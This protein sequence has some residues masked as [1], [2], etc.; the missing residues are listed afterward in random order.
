MASRPIVRE[1]FWKKDDEH[2]LWGWLMRGMSH[3]NASPEAIGVYHDAMEHLD[4][5]DDYAGELQALGALLYS[6]A[7]YGFDYTPRGQ[8]SM[9]TTEESIGYDLSS[10][11]QDLLDQGHL[12]RNIA[13]LPPEGRRARPITDEDWVEP[14]I[15]L[16]IQGFRKDFEDV[17]EYSANV[18]PYTEEAMQAMI[19]RT[20][21]WLRTGYRRMHRRWNGRGDYLTKCAYNICV[22]TDDL[23]KRLTSMLGTEEGP[24]DARLRVR[25]WPKTGEH[26]VHVYFD[27]HSIADRW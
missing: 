22:E 24:R 21:H 18:A 20:R 12:L 27:G 8:P 19:E 11:L 6:R 10:L 2:G 17:R 15:D 3:F 4:Y 7:G 1:F 9:H 13:W 23:T 16:C 14:S 5:R 26:S 25:F